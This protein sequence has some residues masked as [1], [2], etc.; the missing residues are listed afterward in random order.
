LTDVAFETGYADPSHFTHRFRQFVRC[1]PSQY[2]R[3]VVAQR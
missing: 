2:Q 1:L 3:G